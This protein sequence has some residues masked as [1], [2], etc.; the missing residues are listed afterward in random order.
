MCPAPGLRARALPL[1]QRRTRALCCPE[2]RALAARNKGAS[3]NLGCSDTP[4]WGRP[5]SIL[6]PLPQLGDVGRVA[7]R[8][9]NSYSCSVISIMK[10]T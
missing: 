1:S 8:F 3:A 4:G 2:A 7:A 9:G 5:P 6:E 10:S